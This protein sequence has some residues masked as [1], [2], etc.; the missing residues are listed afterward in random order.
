MEQ[1]SDFCVTLS[2]ETPISHEDKVLTPWR[3]DFNSS[4]P[5]CLPNVTGD[6]SGAFEKVLSVRTSQLL[7]IQHP[8]VFIILSLLHTN[9]VDFS[10][11]YGRSRLNQ[12]SFFLWA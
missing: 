6:V 1:T 8:T 12:L 9:P 5:R 3:R 2:N 11:V 4:T 7:D 10:S